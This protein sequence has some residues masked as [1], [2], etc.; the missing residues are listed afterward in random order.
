MAFWKAF[1]E[2]LSFNG[3][4]ATKHTSF[5]NE[6]CKLG[7]CEYKVILSAKRIIVGIATNVFAKMVRILKILFMNQLI[8]VMKL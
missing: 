6:Q 2:L 4:L 3:Y 5:N 7:Q 1:I 8:C